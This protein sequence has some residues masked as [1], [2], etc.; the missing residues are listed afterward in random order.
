MNQIIRN[1][2]LAALAGIVVAGCATPKDSPSVLQYIPADTPY[3]IAST[4]PLPERLVAEPRTGQQQ[5]KGAKTDSCYAS[6]LVTHAGIMSGSVY[7]YFRRTTISSILGRSLPSITRLTFCQAKLPSSVGRKIL[8]DD[9]CPP[10]ASVAT[11]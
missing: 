10:S 7:N 6:H 3:V 4:E 11:D 1:L 5:T 2:S 9:P 8:V